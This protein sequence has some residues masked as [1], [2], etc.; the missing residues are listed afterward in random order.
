MMICKA[1]FEDLF[2]EI[3][4]PGITRIARQEN[5]GGQAKSI[6]PSGLSSDAPKMPTGANLHAPAEAGA[7]FSTMPAAVA[8]DAAW[9]MLMTYDRMIRD[10]SVPANNGWR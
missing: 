4:S 6:A 1:D 9:A 2:P 5:D 10:Y 3:F 7:V 8:C